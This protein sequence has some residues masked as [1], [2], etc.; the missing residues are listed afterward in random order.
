MAVR[1][2]EA[3]YLKHPQARQVMEL[4]EFLPAAYF[5]AKDA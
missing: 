4:F 2:D 3:F 5:Y 1:Y